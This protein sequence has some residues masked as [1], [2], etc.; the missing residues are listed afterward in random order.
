MSM[1]IQKQ[2]Y[3]KCILFVLLL[4]NNINGQIQV[5]KADEIESLKKG[6]TYIPKL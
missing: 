5:F 3:I 4:A 2:L 1:K 6:T